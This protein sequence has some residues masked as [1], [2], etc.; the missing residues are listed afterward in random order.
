[1]SYNNP[2]TTN[3]V[4][5]SVDL[6]GPMMRTNPLAALG[7]VLAAVGCNSFDDK[8]EIGPNDPILV[9][10]T[11]ERPAVQAET[12]P[13][14]VSGG[15]LAVSEDGALAVAADSDRDRVVV[16]DLNGK[17][18]RGIVD[19]NSG[20]EPGRVV[21]EG[22][23]RAYVALRRGGAVAVIDLDSSQLLERQELCS[24]PRGL[25]LDASAAL[26]HVACASGDLVTVSTTDGAPTRRL[27]LGPDLRDVVITGETLMVSRFRSAEILHLDS[28]GNVLGSVFPATVRTTVTR[29][30]DSGQSLG[31]ENVDRSLTPSVAWRM[32][33]NGQGGA[34][35]LHERGT[36]GQIELSAPTEQGASSYGGDSPLG[37]GSIVQSAVTELYVDNTQATSRPIAALTLGVDLAV[38]PTS[39]RLLIANA[40]LVDPDAPQPRT[41]FLGDGPIGIG[42]SAPAVSSDG[43]LRMLDRQAVEPVSGTPEFFGTCTGGDAASPTEQPIVSVAFAPNDVLVAQTR[44]PSQLILAQGSPAGESSVIDLGGRSVLDTGHELFHRDSGGGIACASCHPEGREDGRVWEFAGV[45]K[46][47]TQPLDVGLE[48]TQPFH[49]SGDLPG[50]SSLVDEVFV[51]RMG[52]VLQSKSRLSTLQHWLFARQPLTPLRAGDDA[53]VERGREIFDSRGVGCS[54]CHQGEKLTHHDSFQVREGSDSFQ[55]PSLIG[56]GYRAP[57]MH[58]GCAATLEGRFDPACGGGELHGKTAHLSDTERAD[59]VSFLQSL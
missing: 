15:T 28:Q 25:A 40:G 57:F 9:I 56:V 3:G 30:I 49:W 22:S 29:Q 14:P 11:D 44:E 18:V 5:P 48:G 47:R 38:S 42:G 35:V 1:M 6:E 46:R 27:D 39:G 55:V 37:C 53:S 19:L 23:S 51:S 4:G 26:L 20:D 50:L 10:P 16:V 17:T 7:L 52:G 45:G 34:L 12:P 32:V 54:T 24:D 58:D 13:P 43:S 41:V 36:E 8:S 31:V 2:W 59:L 21:L 33:S